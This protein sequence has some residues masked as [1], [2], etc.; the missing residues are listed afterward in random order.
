VGVV[1]WVCVAEA[2]GDDGDVDVGVGVWDGE[3][4]VAGVV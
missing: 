1:G 2:V 3:V 4:E